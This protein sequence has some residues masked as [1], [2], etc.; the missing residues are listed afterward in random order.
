MRPLRRPLALTIALATLVA[1]GACGDGGGTS[2]LSAYEATSTTS[3]TMHLV[4]GY[5]TTST[6]PASA[7]TTTTTVPAREPLVVRLTNEQDIRAWLSSS[8]SELMGR[9]VIGE[10][11]I[12]GFVK[13]YHESE[14]YAQTAEYN[15]ESYTAT[16]SLEAASKDWIERSFPVEVQAYR[17]MQA[18]QMMEKAI[19][20]L[21]GGSSSGA[22][23]SL[24]S[25]CTKNGHR[26]WGTVRVTDS[27]FADLTVNVTDSSF[28]DL[29]VRRTSYPS[30]CGDW[31]FVDSS[32]A[33]FTVRFTDSSF[34]DLTIRFAN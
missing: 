25:T 19:S 14:T 15:G 16:P 34:A 3:T 18:G 4:P 28:A 27:S 9:G 26:L 22:S 7:Y 29:T 12:K 1:L 23:S 21:G 30:Q 17:I 6:L 10:G 11:S 13:W 32:F 31:N 5:A 2:G 8:A 33:D 24:G 20:D